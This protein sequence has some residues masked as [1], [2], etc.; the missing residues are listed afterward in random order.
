[1]PAYVIAQID[2]H[3]PKAYERYRAEVPAKMHQ[4]GRAHV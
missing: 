3:D 1:M 4:I 2:I